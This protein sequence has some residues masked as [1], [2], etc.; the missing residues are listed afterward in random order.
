MARA[1]FQRS[2]VWSSPA[3]STVNDLGTDSGVTHF[4]VLEHGAQLSVRVLFVDPLRDGYRKAIA[5]VGSGS[6]ADTADE[7]QQIVHDIGLDRRAH[8]E[9]AFARRGTARRDP[10]RQGGD[11]RDPDQ[12][13]YPPKEP[14]PFRRSSFVDRSYPLTRLS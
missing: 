8:Q 14:L 11:E 10:P 4:P 13:P 5:A 2:F 12:A 9:P 6:A 1:P 3:C 7:I